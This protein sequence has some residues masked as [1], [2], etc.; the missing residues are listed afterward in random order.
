MDFTRLRSL[1]ETNPADWAGV[2]VTFIGIL[3]A[4][5]SIWWQLRKQWLLHS[6]TLIASLD[7]RFHS[8]EWRGHRVA[9]QRRLSAHVG[10]KEPLDLSN[11]LPVLG[12]FENMAYLVRKGAL[13]E[14]MVW[15]KF[16]WYVV[17][18]YLAVTRWKDANQEN[19]IE[20]YR[21][22]ARDP[23]LYEEFVWLYIRCAEISHKRGVPTYDCC[24]QKT[25]IDDLLKNEGALLSIQVA[26][27]CTAI[28]TEG[29]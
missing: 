25:M 9:G 17:G 7:E 27:C 4:G 11:D 13:H 16:S 23:T 12:F 26:D 24:W 29:D 10:K 3:V 28:S 19:A 1:I 21:T 8:P 14:G 2:G 6:A 18:Y 20:Q 5:V 22:K 15:N